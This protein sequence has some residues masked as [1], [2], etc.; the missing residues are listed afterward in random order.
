MHDRLLATTERVNPP[1]S[2][3][4]NDNHH[5]GNAA[6]SDDGRFVAFEPDSTVHVPN[7]TNGVRDVFVRDRQLGLTSESA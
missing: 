5:S 3:L 6:I 7:D 4:P 1:L 2:G